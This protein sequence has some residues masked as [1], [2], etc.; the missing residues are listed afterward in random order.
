MH[1]TEQHWLLE[2]YQKNNSDCSRG[3]GCLQQVWTCHCSTGGPG[4]WRVWWCVDLLKWCVLERKADDIT[5]VFPCLQTWLSVLHLDRACLGQSTSTE[6]LAKASS[7]LQHRPWWGVSST[8]CPMRWQGWPPLGPSS[9]APQ[10]LMATSTMVSTHCLLVATTLW[11]K[12]VLFSSHLQSHFADLI[13][14][15]FMSRKVFVMRC[16][17]EADFQFED[18]KLLVLKLTLFSPYIATYCHSGRGLLPL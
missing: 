7:P 5:I 9:Q 6:V 14:G 18:K 3:R 16:G 17:H 2:W 12:L 11:A 4:C 13:I 15:A 8:W 10:T 1:H